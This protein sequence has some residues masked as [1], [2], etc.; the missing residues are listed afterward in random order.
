MS[1][2]KNIEFKPSEVHQGHY[3]YIKENATDIIVNLFP[4]ETIKEYKA[5]V[6]KRIK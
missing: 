4:Y 5:K 1:N 2:L 3:V 6:D